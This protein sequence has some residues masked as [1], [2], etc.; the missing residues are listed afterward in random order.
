MDEIL[1]TEILTQ[2][3]NSSQSTTQ[4][5]EKVNIETEGEDEPTKTESAQGSTTMDDVLLTEILHQMATANQSSTQKPGESSLTSTDIAA[6]EI[7]SE[8]DKNFVTSTNQIE[9]TD[10]SST[11]TNDVIDNE[12]DEYEYDG[13]LPIY[14]RNRN[15][16]GI[17]VTDKFFKKSEARTKYWLFSC[18]YG[19]E[20]TMS[21]KNRVN[22]L[23]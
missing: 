15:L 13:T 9:V 8:V 5:P 14:N 20:S 4:K 12:E 22:N 19:M 23:K 16:I 6:E 17:F 10:L 1:L 21:S 2:I 7:A 11:S 3:A 18:F